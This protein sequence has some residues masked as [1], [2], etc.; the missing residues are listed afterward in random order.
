MRLLRRVAVVV[1]LGSCLGLTGAVPSGCRDSH[2]PDPCCKHCRT[3][4][5]CGDSCINC[6]YQ[7]TKPPGCACNG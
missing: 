7:C 4:C 5:A 2:S 1:A 6:S 3:G